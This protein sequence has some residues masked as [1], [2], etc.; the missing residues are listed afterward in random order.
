MK[1]DLLRRGVDQIIPIAELE[2]ALK[3]GR[4][5]RIKFG[6]DPTRPD[7]H[8]G[9]AVVL[10]ILRELQGLGHTVIFLIGDYTTKI[11]DPSGRSKTRPMLS[12]EEIE[13]NIKTYLDQVGLILDV[14][15]AEVRRNSEWLAKLSFADLIDLASKMSVAQLIERD[16]F[17][18]RLGEGH[19]LALHELL[20]PL[21]QAYDSV[22]LEADVE[23]GGTDQLFNLLAGR[24]LQK[25]MDQKPQIVFTAKLLVGTDGVQKMSKSLDN[26]IGVTEAPFEMYGKIMSIP[27]HLIAPYY[28]LCTDVELDVI[29]ELVKTLAAGANPRDT[30][31]SLAREIISIYHSTDDARVAEERWNGLFRNKQG[32]GEDEFQLHV[33]K[34]P[35][36]I[37]DLLVDLGAA[38]SKSE[39]RRLVEQRGVSVNDEIANLEATAKPGDT[40]KVGKRRF[41]KLEASG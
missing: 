25:K 37:V 19:E 35:K 7:I 2:S 40:I 32:P 28:E 20:Y 36:L 18:K 8:L 27:D 14:K 23:F 11:G 16:D 13:A 12:D 26:Y 9:H 21:M 31:A 34:V 29:D 24:A 10:R 15:K 4:K 17:K 30:K 39:A 1:S 41:Y 22:A 3:S 33:T 38:A 6:V 5:L